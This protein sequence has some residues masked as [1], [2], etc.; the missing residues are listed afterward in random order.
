MDRRVNLSKTALS[1]VGLNLVQIAALIA[2]ILYSCLNDNIP[3]F[4]VYPLNEYT[5]FLILGA[6]ALV[7]I[8]I[9]LRNRRLLDEDGKRT[10]MLQE[11]FSRLEK[12]NNTLR[13]QRHDFLNHLQVVYGLIEMEEYKE[14]R[15][16]ID[17]IYA[18]IQKVGRALKTSSPAINALLQAK[19][20]DCEKRGISMNVDVSTQLSGLK[21]PSWEMC[22]VLGNLIDNAIYALSENT[23][24]KAISAE[25]FEDLE[26]FRFRV[27]DNGS[28]I[29]SSSMEKI[30]EPGYTTKGVKG[31]GMGLSIVR[32]IL[33]AYGG[34]ISVKST[35][36][37]TCFEGFL[38]K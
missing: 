36:G 15:D 22:R 23:G 24:V 12:L 21:I 18:D 25:L 37:S 35:E 1:A 32:D 13:A 2:L 8:F 19:L 27:I 9:S 29:P 28:I 30:F 31:E 16:Y 20:I 34:N 38:P 4:K 33:T 3:S 11:A 6:S 10:M 17:T 5:I 14:A 7:N 26:S